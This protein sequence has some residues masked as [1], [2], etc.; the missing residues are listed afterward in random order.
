MRK[1][2]ASGFLLVL[3]A[4]ALAIQPASA[5]TMATC[6]ADFSTCYIPENVLLQ[7]PFLGISGDVVL[8]DPL[9]SVSDVFRIFNDFIDT[10]KGTGLGG[11]AFLYSADDSTPL[12]PPSTYSAN[13]Q[14]IPES[15]SSPQT[16]YFGNG[17]IY[18]LAAPE[19]SSWALFGIGSIAL[20]LAHRRK[21]PLWKTA[22][23]LAMALVCLPAFSQEIPQTDPLSPSVA[24][25]DRPLAM[26]PA[27]N[28]RA[29]FS[30]GNRLAFYTANYTSLG[31]RPLPFNIVGTDPA[32]G[33][34]TTT[35][36]TML[37]PLR[38]LFA[39]AGE[40]RH[41][42]D[43]GRNQS[44]LVPDFRRSELFNGWNRRGHN[45]IRRRASSGAV[46][47]SAGILP[48]LSRSAWR[49]CHH[50]H[51]DCH[52]S[53]EHGHSL[54]T[55]QWKSPRRHPAADCSTRCSTACIQNFTAQVLPIF[56]TDNVFL[57]ATGKLDTTCCI[58]GFHASQGPPIATAQ[59]WIYA[60]LH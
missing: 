17:T 54:S 14:F 10:G 15:T 11:T 19:P 43:S 9:G 34:N 18:V 56:V 50:Q 45:P 6:S 7:L 38:I 36:N 47:E 59:T 52:Y 8:E 30:S 53:R 24:K 58:L 51:I 37:V 2:K 57:S 26:G 25:F 13:V 49:T 12:P 22:L 44:S 29:P 27:Q 33:A 39:S 42:C 1:C 60:S 48:R 35:V 16:H 41:R 20:L 4:L 46:L 32:L 5:A 31:G 21:A 3:T 40:S 23:F 28:A 55:E